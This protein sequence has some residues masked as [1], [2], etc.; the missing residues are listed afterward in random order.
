M[1]TTIR[2]STGVDDT[3]Y[4]S[5]TGY[6]LPTL[7]GSLGPAAATLFALL[8]LALGTW[9]LVTTPLGIVAL[10]A[11]VLL[12]P[13]LVPTAVVVLVTRALE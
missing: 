1:R 5:T 4:G 6:R 2:E 9:L 10:Y 11:L 3:G 12:L 13:L 7:D 8:V